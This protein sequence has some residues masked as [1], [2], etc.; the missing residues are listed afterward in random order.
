[1]E[2]PMTNTL[3]GSSRPLVDEEIRAYLA[4]VMSAFGPSST[5][6]AWPNGPDS[7]TEQIF[8]VLTDRQFCHLSR[9]ATAPYRDRTLSLLEERVRVGEPLAFWYDVGPG[10][11][12]SLRPGELD[13][14]FDIG[15]SELLILFQIVS[16]CQRVA[17]LY[18]PGARFSLVVDNLCALRTNDIPVTQTAGYCLRF[19]ELIRELGLDDRVGMTVESEEFDLDEYDDILAGIE[20]EQPAAPLSGDD[21]ENVERFL[22]RRCS[23]GEA[24]DRADRYRRTGMV[25]EHLLLR[26]VRGVRMTQRASETTLGFR[27]FPGGDSRTQCGEVAIGRNAKGKLRPVLLTSRNIDDY[28]CVRVGDLDDL[29]LPISHVTFAEKIGV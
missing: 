20:P 24:V 14:S 23:L 7:L 4:D 15:L 28:D 3:Q 13:L 8:T 5:A 29:S 1:M 16:F 18:P 22:G 21:L 11:H 9:G 25:T 27:A 6:K 12:A 17:E 2:K 26:V 19:R 10:Y